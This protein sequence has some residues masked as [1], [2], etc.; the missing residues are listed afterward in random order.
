MIRRRE[1]PDGLPF[2]L[3]ERVGVRTYSI[4]YKGADGIWSFRLQ[5]P[6]DDAAQ[7][8]QLRRDA[9]KRA[10]D[11]NTIAPADDTFAALADVWLKWQQSLPEGSATRRADST[12]AE[13]ANEL[14]TLKKSF[15]RMRVDEM[16]KSDAY[17][18]LDA[19]LPKTARGGAHHEFRANQLAEAERTIMHGLG[20]LPA[21]VEPGFF[22]AALLLRQQ[23][24]G[25]AANQPSLR[26]P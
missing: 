21:A 5:C 8:A 19:C 25:P 9:I 24:L 20:V 22:P 15:G 13:N 18:H 4:G 14:R 1:K 3:Y 10:A 12:L 17:D 23:R 7:V 26:R 2:R 6:V 16:V 11:I